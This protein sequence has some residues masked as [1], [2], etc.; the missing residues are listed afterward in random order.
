MDLGIKIWD[1]RSEEE[2]RI[3]AGSASNNVLLTHNA[4]R[5]AVCYVVDFVTGSLF[6]PNLMG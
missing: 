3:A 6:T 4:W 1:K 2:H 5:R